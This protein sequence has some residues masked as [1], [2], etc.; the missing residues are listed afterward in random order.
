MTNF[1][2]QLRNPTF[3]K[4]NEWKKAETISG[5]IYLPKFDNVDSLNDMKMMAKVTIYD[6]W[7]NDNVAME[8]DICFNA[9]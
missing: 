8:K 2:L 7:I 9:L 1:I 3:T 4:E 6:T 5:K